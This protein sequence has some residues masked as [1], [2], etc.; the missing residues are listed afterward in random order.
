MF[1]HAAKCALFLSLIR[2]G[3]KMLLQSDG[4]TAAASGQQER[5]VQLMSTALLASI[6]R[7][8]ALAAIGADFATPRPRTNTRLQRRS[9]APVSC[10][11]LARRPLTT[12][13]LLG[14]SPTSQSPPTSGVC[15]ARCKGAG[16]LQNASSG[17]SGD[18]CS[19]GFAP[20]C[21]PTCSSA[22]GVELGKS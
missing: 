15:C 4:V 14:V 7:A 19:H 2:D 21:A 20:A 9:G 16:T 18:V 8:V 17:A 1:V 13:G 6:A 22:E 3:Q 11:T 5:V 10:R 12:Q